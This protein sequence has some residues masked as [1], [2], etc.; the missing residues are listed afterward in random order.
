M[1]KFVFSVL[2]LCGLGAAVQAQNTLADTIRLNPVEVKEYLVKKTPYIRAELPSA[3]LQNMAT[4][5]VGDALRSVPNVAGVRKGGANLDPVV[6][7]FKYSQINTTLNYGLSIEGGCPNRMDPTTS[8]VD[9]DDIDRIEVFKGPYAVRFGPVFGSVVNLVTIQ[10]QPYEKFQAHVKAVTGYTGNWDGFKE[11]LRVTFGNRYA[12]FL[13]SGNYIKFGNYTDGGGSIVNAAYNKYSYTVKAG[14]SPFKKHQFILGYTGA[15]GRNIR[16]PALQMDERSDNTGIYS[17]DYKATAL[18][19]VVN[20]V[21]ARV[22]YADVNHVMDNKQRSTSDTMAAISDVDASTLGGRA[23]I[24]LSVGKKMVLITGLSYL[25]VNKDG[26]R[27]KTMIMQPPMNGA[28]PVKTEQLWNKARISNYGFFAEYKA[29]I[30]TWDLFAALRLDYNTATS[31]P[32][33]YFGTGTPPPLILDIQNTGSAL[34]NVSG[35]LGLGKYIGNHFKIDFAVGRGVRSPNMVERFIILLPVGYDN[36][37]Y[38]GNPD[39]KAEANNEADLTFRFNHPKAGGFELNGFFS[40]VQDYIAGKVVPYSV[41][42]PTSNKILGVKQFQNFDAAWFTGFEFAYSL[43][44]EW[45]LA[46]RVTAAYTYGVYPK[47]TRVLLD[48]SR[49]PSQQIIGEEEITNDAVQEIP[50]FEA[51]VSVSYRFLKNRLIPSVSYRLVLAQKHVSRAY[52]ETETPG[53][54]LFGISLTYHMNKMFSVSGGVNNLFDANY[55]EHLNRRTQGTLINLHEPG[56]V[57]YVNVMFNI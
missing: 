23:E 27:I 25:D 35:S 21:V 26:Q 31:G 11:H 41:L 36:Y 16:F 40:Y 42:K 34:F 52:Y 20:S 10:P 18:S 55:Y 32:V 39:L 44:A 6:R 7:G 8:R 33:Q 57:F 46:A 37:E 29:A 4:G 56:R 43:P 53:F 12:Y 24:N 17:L 22:Y 50:P 28:I 15:F 1:K 47:I 2:I 45:K 54:N 49:I 3:T 19:D 38:Y 13:L 14:F 30:S 5:D 9:I 48:P 51:Q